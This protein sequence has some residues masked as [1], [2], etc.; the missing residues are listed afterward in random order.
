LSINNLKIIKVLWLQSKFKHLFWNITKSEIDLVNVLINIVERDDAFATEGID[1]NQLGY[2]IDTNMHELSSSLG[3]LELRIETIMQTLESL[4]KSVATIYHENDNSVL[5]SK[6]TF[7]YQYN[8]SST[9]NDINKRLNIIVNTT[10]VK[11]LRN[12]LHLFALL[13]RIDKY[14]LKS[15]YSKIIYEKF[16]KKDRTVST[17]SIEELVRMIDFGLEYKE[18]TWSRL[19]SNILKRVSKELNEKTNLYF[20]YNKIKSTVAE[21][22]RVQT[23]EVRIVTHVAPEVEDPDT[24][25]SKE[26]L[27][28]RKVAYYVERDINRKFKEIT[29]F[30]TKDAI[31]N[32]EAYKHKL[33]KEAFKL[34]DE[35]EAKVL[36][37]EW[38]NNI[39]YNNYE[40]EG[41][42]VLQD[43]SKD[44]QFITVNNNYKLY[45]I[46]KG[47]E[48]STSARDTRMKI[49]SFM[50][51]GHYDIVETT[52]YIKN[53]SISYTMG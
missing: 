31:E 51:K 34:R 23:A 10:L 9:D 3:F 42:V 4:S 36:L 7:V 13:Y 37:Q 24:Y 47:V 40:H 50:K 49:Q 43:Y 6:A 53:C 38:L 11:L 33:R 21:T 17:Y 8:I 19:N 27:M 15:K 45:D 29:R 12:N 39:K 20:E 22:N 26:F 52:E 28:N 41:L 30:K 48:V 16:Y 35:Y 32:P 44:N 25:F 14:G 18:L 5:M 2:V 46:E 1:R